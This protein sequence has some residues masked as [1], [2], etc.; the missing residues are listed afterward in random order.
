MTS[1][2][3]GYPYIINPEVLGRSHQLGGFPAIECP[4]VIYPRKLTRLNI[5]G[6]QGSRF[7]LYKDFVSDATRLDSTQRGASNTADYSG[8]PLY[9]G[10]GVRLI[11]VW[12]VAGNGYGTFYFDPGR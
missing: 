9:V 6:P 11:G 10:P 4:A 5:N 8:G 7:S 1:M 12:T 3:G 2:A